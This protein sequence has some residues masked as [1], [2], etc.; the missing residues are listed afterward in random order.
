[1]IDGIDLADRR[2]LV[3]GGSSGIGRAVVECYL[4]HG[5]TV[6]VLSR[7]DPS[8]WDPA[9]QGGRGVSWIKADLAHGDDLQ[10]RLEA[11]F[12]DPAKIPDIIFHAA[13]S[14]GGPSRSN[15]EDTDWRHFEEATAVNVLGFARLLRIALPHLV[16]KPSALIASVTSE[17]VFNAGPGRLSYATTKAAA[18][19]IMEGLR[20]EL[21]P[22]PVRI[23]ELLPHGMVLTPGIVRRRGGSFDSSGYASPS[24]FENVVLHLA[25]T[26][27]VDHHGAC[28]VVK[29][30]G[31]FDTLALADLPS[32][33]KR[34]K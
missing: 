13:T 16:S 25:R 22:S 3:T 29:P 6:T 33:S 10:I 11:E 31:S 26:M 19:A 27:G 32:Q 34:T 24:S 20:E 21:A 7:R 2:V 17:V 9:W 14:Y 28:L 23:V 12:E 30:D 5:A 1:M 4:R 18:H 15:F 8:L